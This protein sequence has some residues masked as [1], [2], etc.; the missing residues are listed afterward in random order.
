MTQGYPL[1]LGWIKG[2]EQLLLL[3][4]AIPCISTGIYGYPADRAA[5]IAVETV[6]QN[7]PDSVRKSNVSN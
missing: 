5:D 6:L 1:L 7:L 4:Q 3:T 2:R